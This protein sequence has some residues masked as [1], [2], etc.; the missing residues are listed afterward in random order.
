MR[1][2][3]AVRPIG[4]RHPVAGLPHGPMAAAFS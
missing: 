4:S 3:K 2:H 1:S